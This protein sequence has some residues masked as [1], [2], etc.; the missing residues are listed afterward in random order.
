MRAV[1]GS[2]LFWALGI[3]HAMAFVARGTD[4]IL[5]TFFQSMGGDHLTPAIAGGLTLSITLGLVHGLV[6]GQKQFVEAKSVSGR[7]KFLKRRYIQSVSATIGLM[8]TAQYGH[9]LRSSFL[10]TSLIAILSGAMASNVAFQY[11]QFPAKIAKAKFGN[12]QAIVISF[13]DGFGFLLSAPIFAMCS[14]LISSLG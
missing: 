10:R 13:L 9:I 5:G 1:F 12:H 3:A 6:T 8:V 7:K 11:F 4:R 2:P 14:R